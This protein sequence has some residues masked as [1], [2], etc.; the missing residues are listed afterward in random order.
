MRNEVKPRLGSANGAYHTTRST[1]SY[2][3]EKLKK[4]LC[5]D[6]P[7]RPGQQRKAMNRNVLIFERNNLRD[8]HGATLNPESGSHERKQKTRSIFNRPQTRV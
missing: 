2:Y 8:I 3:H 6:R 7:V 4:L 5:D 1:L